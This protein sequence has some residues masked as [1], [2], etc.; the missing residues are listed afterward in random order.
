[1]VMGG[2]AFT[3]SAWLDNDEAD[4]WA[5]VDDVWVFDTATQEWAQLLAP[6]SP[7]QPAGDGPAWGE[8]PEACIE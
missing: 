2:H 3:G 6:S 5:S 8:E 7:P 4:S 1:M